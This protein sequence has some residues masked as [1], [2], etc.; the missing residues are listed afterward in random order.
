[1]KS[2]RRDLNSAVF[3]YQVER[4]ERSTE[5]GIGKEECHSAKNKP[6]EDS[7]MQLPFAVIISAL[8]KELSRSGPPPRTVTQV[9][10]GQGCT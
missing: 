3:G 7:R 5:K 1:M 10:P 9:V 6:A 8:F 2:K 4:R